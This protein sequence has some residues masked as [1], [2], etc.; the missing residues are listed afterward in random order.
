MSRISRFAIAGL[1]STGL[2]YISF[3]IFY[4]YI[5]V[6][7]F[8]NSFVFSLFINVSFSFCLQRIFVFRS[9]NNW[10]IEYFKFFL[11]GFVIIVFGY[12]TLYYFVEIKKYDPM[13]GNFLVVSFSSLLS[14]LYHSFI[15]F[16]G[17]GHDN[18]N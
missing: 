10:L 5:S 18:F 2:A 11:G 8:I 6:N 12:T 16:K 13:V 1:F 7:N 9:K 17:G 14:Y 15:T 3:P 4:N